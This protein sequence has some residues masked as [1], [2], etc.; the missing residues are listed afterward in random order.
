[1][2]DQCRDVVAMLC[3]S[4]KHCFNVALAV[5]LVEVVVI[6]VS[7]MKLHVWSGSNTP[8]EQLNGYADGE[9]AESFLRLYQSY[10]SEQV[11]PKKSNVPV[12]FM[13]DYNNSLCSCIPDTLGLL[14][15]TVIC[16]V[17]RDGTEKNDLLA[18]WSAD[19]MAKT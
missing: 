15:H 16:S 5:I 3:L 11:Y 10:C 17:N 9:S 8:V 4:R 19:V 14:K 6:L 2:T 18:H 12:K 1:M 7:E 13:P